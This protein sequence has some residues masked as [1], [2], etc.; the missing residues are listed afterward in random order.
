LISSASPIAPEFKIFDVERAA[1]RALPAGTTAASWSPSSPT[2]EVA[3][4]KTVAKKEGGAPVSSLNIYTLSKGTSR[5]VFELPYYDLL[6]DWIT[7]SIISF[8]QKPTREAVGSIWQYNLQTKTLRPLLIERTGL[9]SSWQAVSSI[10]YDVT[11]GLYLLSAQGTE[12]RLPFFSLPTKC[13]QEALQL[14]CAVPQGDFDEGSLPD[15]Y[16][17]RAV[18]T[19]DVFTATSLSELPRFSSSKVLLEKNGPAIDAWHLVKVGP[20]LYFINR[21]DQKVYAL[22]V[23]TD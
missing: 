22:R 14:Y 12:T 17:Q 21:Y 13:T 20:R 19:S 18:M 4:L 10:H 8:S 23:L 9:W 16:I 3:F 11:N 5:Q 1:W 2:N 6:I 7:P 15:S